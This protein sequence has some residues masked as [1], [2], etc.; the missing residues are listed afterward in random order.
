MKATVPVIG[1]AAPSGTGKTTLIERVITDLSSTGLRVAAIKHGH[2]PADPDQPGK[3]T[4]RFRQAGAR[5][6]LFAC[7]QRWFLIQ[8]IHP[9]EEPDL[10]QQIQLF[11]CHDLVIVEGYKNHSHPQIAIHR[12]GV[13]NPGFILNL[14]NIAAVATDDGNLVLDLQ[15]QPPL[16]PLN[17]PKIVAQF[18]RHHLALESKT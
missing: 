7:A 11:Q 17:E 8:E 2:H 14:K 16:L 13:T 10:E 15:P 4:Y 5:S 1:F 18:I 3:D 9:G 12:K 6:V